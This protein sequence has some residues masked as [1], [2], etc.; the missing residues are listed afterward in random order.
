LLSFFVSA[1]RLVSVLPLL[2]CFGDAGWVLRASHDYFLSA[3]GYRAKKKT[4]MS[5][6]ILFI[7]SGCCCCFFF[8][9]LCFF[10][11]FPLLILGG[12][13]FVLF[14]TLRGEETDSD[15]YCSGLMLGV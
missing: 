12:A 1:L 8:F 13:T 11:F 9:L 2:L 14:S 6:N 5:S 3:N 4:L 7:N 10:G 15:S